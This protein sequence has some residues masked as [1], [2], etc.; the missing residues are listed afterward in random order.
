MRPLTVPEEY[1]NSSLCFISRARTFSL[2][3]AMLTA[4]AVSF[5]ATRAAAQTGS[6]SV[7][8]TFTNFV[9]PFASGVNASNPADASQYGLTGTVNGVTPSYVSY[10]GGTGR[11]VVGQAAIAP[12][13]TAVTLQAQVFNTPNVFS[14]VTRPFTN[15]ALGQDFVL[16][17][18]TFENGAWFGAINSYPTGVDPITHLGFQITTTSPNGPAFNQTIAGWISM[19]VYVS[20]GADPNTLV[21]QNAQADWLTIESSAAVSSLGAFRVYEECCRPAG[22]STVGSVDLIARFNSLDLVGFANP[23][24]GF[25]TASVDPLPNG[26]TV[27]TPEPATLV[28]VAAGLAACVAVRRRRSGAAS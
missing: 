14:F 21:G 19:H 17:T 4:H 10:N 8:F 26:A 11:E 13:T 7:S 23:R 1:M 18:L 25:V 20:S 6:G 27:T 3:L 2:A 5:G 12:G 22:F 9:G 15:V 24:G 28:L 16:G